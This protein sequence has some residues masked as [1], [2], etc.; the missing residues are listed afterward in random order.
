[1][2]KKT[3]GGLMDNFENLKTPKPQLDTSLAES[4]IENTNEVIALEEEKPKVKQTIKEEKKKSAKAETTPAPVEAVKKTS[5]YFKKS[6]H[7]AVRLHCVKN[8][9][10]ITEYLET[11]IK[12]DLKI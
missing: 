8:E 6:T 2:A 10:T 4:V 7:S 1:M 12:K 5:L 9:L 3:I 11:I